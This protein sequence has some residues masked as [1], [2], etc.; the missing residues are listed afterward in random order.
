M[1]IRSSEYEIRYCE[2][3]VSDSERTIEGTIVR[4]DDEANIAGVFRERI[5]AGAFEFRSDMFLNAQHDRA[6]PLA[7]L[8]STKE[9]SFSI[10]QSTAGY[11]IRARIARTTIGDDALY[12]VRNGLLNGFSVEMKV[13]DE[14]WREDASLRVINRATMVGVALVDRPA[15]PQ[16]SVEARQA[17]LDETFADYLRK[18]PVLSYHL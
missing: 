9:A 4:F 14:D 18:N 13:H 3:R 8:N 17:F 5:T 2:V 11:E 7:K 1:A 12:N 15:Y 10:R 6:K 16:S